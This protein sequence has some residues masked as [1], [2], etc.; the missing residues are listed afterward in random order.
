MD[1]F[2]T[3]RTTSVYIDRAPPD[4]LK[5][6]LGF[7]EEERGANLWLIVPDD[8]GVFHCTSTVEG[9]RCVHPVQAFLDLKGHA[10]RSAEAA[11]HLRASLISE[12][13]NA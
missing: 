8:E 1:H 11:A 13:S 6:E 12:I 9:I 4:D 2:A 7:R 10:E 5:D 3:F